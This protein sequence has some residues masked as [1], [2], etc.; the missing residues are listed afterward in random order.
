MSVPC[1][2]CGR[3]AGLRCG[4]DPGR[5]QDQF[6]AEDYGDRASWDRLSCHQERHWLYLAG[7]NPQGA[8]RL[9]EVYRRRKAEL[10][11]QRRER[12]RQRED[13]RRHRNQEFEEF[14]PP[15]CPHGKDARRVWVQ[16]R[17][18][19]DD[20]RSWRPWCWDCLVALPWQETAREVFVFFEPQGIDREVVTGFIRERWLKAQADRLDEVIT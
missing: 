10:R 19:E 2:A 11:G 3:A 15:G 12:E 18:D 16:V 4:A 20:R 13:V 5:M 6:D 8:A 17:P 7:G 9:G 14:T 1:P